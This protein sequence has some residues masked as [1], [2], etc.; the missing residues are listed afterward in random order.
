MKYKPFR[1]R[2][3]LNLNKI[4][5]TSISLWLN[6][7]GLPLAKYTFSKSAI[8]KSEAMGNA[9]STDEIKLGDRIG[10]GAYG[11]VFRAEW[12]KQLVAAK[13]IR[14]IFFEN[15]YYGVAR[16][17]FIR[18]FKAEW[19]LLETLKHPNIVEYFTVI[20]PPTKEPPIIVTELL[21]CDLASYIRK[22]RKISFP[23]TIHI[24]IDVAEGLRYLHLY[25]KPAIVHR[26]LASKNILLTHDRRAKIADLGLAKAFPTN[27]MMATCV[28]GTPIYAAPETYPERL[29]YRRFAPKAH[30]TAKIDIFSFGAML[31]EVIV[32]HLPNTLPDPVSEGTKISFFFIYVVRSVNKQ[33]HNNIYLLKQE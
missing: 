11:E 5:V 13:R 19:E 8:P 14:P 25:K 21:D 6:F 12:R 16:T 24:M 18:K 10:E 33:L 22:K 17:E 7:R 9:S 29:G 27:A 1:P 30:Y 3:F 20:V 4:V 15:D 23:E 26:D 32:G 31:L 28:P 2:G